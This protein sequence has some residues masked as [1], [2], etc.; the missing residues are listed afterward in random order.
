MTEETLTKWLSVDLSSIAT[1]CK[2][3]CEEIE[4]KKKSSLDSKKKLAEET[5]AFQQSSPEVIVSEYPALLKSYQGEI[6]NLSRRAKFS[7]VNY[8]QITSFLSSLPDP[9]ALIG[10]KS[11]EVSRLRSQLRQL[12]Q[13][14]SDLTNQAVTV[15]RLEIELKSEKDERERRIQE[16]VMSKEREIRS[17]LLDQEEYAAIELSKTTETC[18]NLESALIEAGDRI[19]ILVSTQDSERSRFEEAIN[20]KTQEIDF[21]TREIEALKHR[22]F[23]SN[24]QAINLSL[25]TA[26]QQKAS[27]LIEQNEYLKNEL[28]ISQNNVAILRKEI[29]EK[30]NQDIPHRTVEDVVIDVP[31]PLICVNSTEDL[32]TSY[33]NDQIEELKNELSRSMRASENQRA[34]MRSLRET[35][36][37]L[38][39]EIKELRYSKDTVSDENRDSG[40]FLALTQAQKDR[41]RNRALELEAER[42]SLRR[43][44]ETFRGRNECLITENMRLIDQNRSFQENGAEALNIETIFK[45][46][47]SDKTANKIQ[48]LL[49]KGNTWIL[50]L[51]YFSFIHFILIIM[52]VKFTSHE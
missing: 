16:L 6:D 34:E 47:I 44:V 22:E 25:I 13:E 48:R 40:S 43:Q 28:I 5:R 45:N 23:S 39:S 4:G 31:P 7:E 32:Q 37:R 20:Q 15:K 41:F 21:L 51:A 11:N 42:D 9:A 38:E 3:K 36:S 24:D 19:K 26:A 49:T 8:Q 10:Q 52:L 33:L 18:Q 30:M 50:I 2:S 14:F 12:E 27:T 17:A 29:Q 35:I 1:D 46:K